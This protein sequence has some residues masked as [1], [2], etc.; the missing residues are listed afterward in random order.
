MPSLLTCDD[1]HPAP[2]GLPF[3]QRAASSER[4]RERGLSGGD[5]APYVPPERGQRLP[6]QPRHLH[7]GDPQPPAHLLL[8][9]P[10]GIP[11]LDQIAETLRQSD[12]KLLERQPQLQ[13]LQDRIIHPDLAGEGPMLVSI[14]TFPDRIQSR[15]I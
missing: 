10:L 9:Q 12:E 4:L 1:P 3:G 13:R 5:G 8:A 15:V 14:C 2:L 7:L 11:E 6:L